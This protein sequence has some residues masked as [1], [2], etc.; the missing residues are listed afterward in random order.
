MPEV[1]LLDK[2]IQLAIG[3]VRVQ[4]ED[5]LNTRDYSSYESTNK[6]AAELQAVVSSYNQRTGS[7]ARVSKKGHVI[8]E[9]IMLAKQGNILRV[10]AAKAIL[11]LATTRRGEIEP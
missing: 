2:E 5:I 3:E 4:L 7:Q 6:I 10:L 1:K 9:G 8:E 11:A